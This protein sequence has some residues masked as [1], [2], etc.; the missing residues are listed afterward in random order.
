[1]KQRA[2]LKVSISQLKVSME[3]CNEKYSSIDVIWKFIIEKTFPTFA[4][5]RSELMCLI[6]YMYENN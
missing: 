6:Y 3:F 5:R 4:V 1:M 2:G